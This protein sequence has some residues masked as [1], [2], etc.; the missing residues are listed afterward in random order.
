MSVERLPDSGLDWH[1]G[2]I[3]T[4]VPQSLE[5]GDIIKRLVHDYEGKILGRGLV[6]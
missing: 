3:R 1:D 2:E 5:S 6:L 4:V